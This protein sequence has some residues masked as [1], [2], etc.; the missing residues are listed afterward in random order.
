[1][2]TSLYSKTPSVTVL[3]N[4]ALLV[5]AIAYHRHP[6]TLDIT[7]ECITRH[8]FD[9]RGLPSQSADPRLYAAGLANFSYLSDLN[10]TALRTQSADAGTSVA[11][12]D[13]SG[14]VF[15]QVSNIGEGNERSAAVTRTFQYEDASLPGRLLGITEQ[16]AGENA[17]A[18]ERFVW[19]GHSADEQSHNLAGQ[20]VSHYDPAGLLSTGSVSLSGVPL[21]VTRQLLPDDAEADWQGVDASAWNDLLAGETYTTNGTVD[22]AGNVLTTTDAKGNLQRVAYD[23][24]GLLKGSWLTVNG[25]SEQIIVKSLTY[26]AAGQKLREEHGNGVVTTYSYEAETQRLIGIKTERLSAAKVLQDLRY[27]YDPVGN[28]LVITNDAEETRFWRNQQVVPENRYAYDSLYQLVSASG[29]EMASAVQQNSSLP[30]YSSF[31]DA[32]YTNYSRTYTYDNAGNLT[33]IRHSAPASGNN[34]TTSITVSS[35]SNRAVLSTFTEN[36]A[37]VDALFTAGGQQKQL[38]P[39]QNLL[40]T[41]RQ[42][43]QKVTPVTR[44][45]AADDSESYRYDASSQRIVKITSQLTG[46]STQTKR[47][48]Y[49]P[50]LELRSSAAEE[51][52]V[53]TVGE[54]GRAQVRVLHWESG[55]PAGISNDQ[56]RYSYDNLTG[57]SSLE[58]DS[59]GELIS[60]EEYYPY[61]GTALF[62]ARSQLEADYKTIRYS[63]KEQDATGLYYYGYRYYQPWAG[64][65]LSADPAGTVDGLNLFRMVRNNPVRFNDQNGFLA[66]DA[67]KLAYYTM[68]TEGRMFSGYIEE[69][70]EDIDA[71]QDIIARQSGRNLARLRKRFNEPAEGSLESVFLKKFDEA[72]FNITHHSDKDFSSP[73]GSVHFLSRHQLEQRGIAFNTENTEALDISMLATTHFAFFSLGLKSERQKG[74]SRFGNVGYHIDFEAMKDHKDFSLLQTH[75]ILNAL[76]RSPIS[77]RKKA[78]FATEDDLIEFNFGLQRN[79]DADE[80]E[81]TVGSIYYGKDM[82]EGLKLSVVND[83]KRLG[84]GTREKLKDEATADINSVVQTFYRPQLLVPGGIKINKQHYTIIHH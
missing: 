47:V 70:P 84:E 51:L 77:D 1:M 13:A 43:L 46:G 79:F 73:E 44:D 66:D 52:E 5:R 11:L 33:K 30:A 26:S 7:D 3:D 61:G 39:G 25:G 58:V 24:A 53:I 23:V 28:V 60:Q 20:P 37:D 62:A 82:S 72:P 22:A 15:L 2:S 49:L 55:Q 16:A 75:D 64:R 81:A 9:A 31:D 63:G 32:T 42:E 78:L 27:E 54:A 17:R 48:I 57:S 6:D 19:G 40:W 21:S 56:I 38:L 12:N 45:G 76:D 50:V 10:G 4:R 83:F 35:R 8:Q 59:S 34:Y 68:L 14:R 69:E 29:R 67:V 36:P 71:A 74:K 65:W 80:G 41:A 18:T